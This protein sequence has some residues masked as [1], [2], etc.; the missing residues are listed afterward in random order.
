MAAINY[1]YQHCIYA[2]ADETLFTAQ[3]DLIQHRS[4]RALE[5][6]FSAGSTKSGRCIEN[7]RELARPPRTSLATTIASIPVY[8][9]TR[10]AFSRGIWISRRMSRSESEQPLATTPLVRY[11]LLT[12]LVR[13][14]PHAD[15]P[16]WQK[17]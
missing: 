8:R 13:F 10:S 15:L 3:F 14:R 9:S 6:Q 17:S 1:D 2:L 7:G 4:L 16:M 5:S 12:T 11:E